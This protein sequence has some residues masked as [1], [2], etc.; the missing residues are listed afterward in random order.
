M[1]I[2]RPAAAAAVSLLALAGVVAA[3][4]GGASADAADE[5]RSHWIPYEQA[6]IAY[7]A[8][9]RCAFAVTG[10][11]RQDE[12]EYRN[13]GFWSDGTVRTQVF[14]GALIIRWRNE[15]AGTSVRRDQS[16]RAF[17]EYRRDGEFRSLTA[18]SGHFSAQMPAGSEP[19]KGIYYIGGRW[20][21]VEDRPDGTRTLVLGPRG[22]VEN[23]CQ[24]LGD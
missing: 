18:L 6:D 21:T 19:G 12:E 16:G 22:T 2:P 11:V 3:T 17:V 20:S 15:E 24:T 7:D 9:E 1:W 10:T 14:R 8:G 23:L 5:G 13:V 4:P